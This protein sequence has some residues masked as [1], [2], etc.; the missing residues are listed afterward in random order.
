MNKNNK[1]IWIF[2][3]ISMIGVFFFGGNVY[4]DEGDNVPKK[5]RFTV[6]INSWKNNNDLEFACGSATGNGQ[7]ITPK[8]YYATFDGYDLGTPQEVSCNFSLSSLNWTTNESY[9]I[10]EEF[11][12]TNY[13]GIAPEF[14]NIVVTPG[15]VTSPSMFDEDDGIFS[16]Y[17]PE[18][19]ETAMVYNLNHTDDVGRITDEGLYVYQVSF[20]TENISEKTN[21]KDYGII[22]IPTYCLRMSFSAR[23]TIASSY[24]TFV[25]SP[26]G[27]SSNAISSEV[28]SDDNDPVLMCDIGGEPLSP[29]DI[30]DLIADVADETE[31]SGVARADEYVF[32]AERGDEEVAS[33]N[34]IITDVEIIGRLDADLSQT[35]LA[36]RVIPFIV[37]I[38]LVLSGYYVVR[39]NQL[40]K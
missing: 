13:H 37:L 4:A 32:T 16:Q 12:F 22:Y 39:K 17:S 40:S 2:L 29:D 18:D 35:G 26:F 30:D 10:I 19:S 8:V 14:E 20:Y 1:K 27:D 3:L 38:G 11:D 25:F 28:T 6:T 34:V 5:L 36:Y 21:E 15:Q 7:T 31:Y 23:G 33:G 24:G 9:Q